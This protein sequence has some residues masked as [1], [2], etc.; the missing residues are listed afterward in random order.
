MKVHR[1]RLDCTRPMGLPLSPSSKTSGISLVC[2]RK[3]QIKYSK[4][5]QK[6]NPNTD[7][8]AINLNFQFS[9][10]KSDVYKMLIL[11]RFAE[12]ML[13]HNLK[14]TRNYMF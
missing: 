13:P 4:K 11:Y 14:N 8:A 7:I 3:P 9:A 5:N 12:L 6:N 2:L 10:Y 1:D